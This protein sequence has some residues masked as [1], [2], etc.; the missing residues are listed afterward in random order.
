MNCPHCFRDVDSMRRVM[1]IEAQIWRRWEDD[2][3]VQVLPGDYM[4]LFEFEKLMMEVGG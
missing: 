3:V 4:T 2:V 1:Q